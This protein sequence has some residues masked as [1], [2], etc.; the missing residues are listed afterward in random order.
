[1]ESGG[2]AIGDQLK[3]MAAQNGDLVL[4]DYLVF[5]FDFR[6]GMN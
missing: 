3:L 5:D 6:Q 4:T 1:M 2:G